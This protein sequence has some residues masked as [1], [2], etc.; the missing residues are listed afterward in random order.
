MPLKSP[1]QL[2]ANALVHDPEVAAVAGQRV[3]PVIAPF[4]AALPFVTWRRSSV[5]RVQTLSGPSGMAA[6]VLAVDMFADTY[7]AARELADR[8]RRVLDG[9]G[10]T[11]E[12]YVSVRSV[13]L[14]TESDGFVQLAGGD[15]PPVYQVSQTYS[16]LWQEI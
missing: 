12:N 16:V 3:Y 6:V 5:G 13:T 11:V 10:T 9:Y 4:S 15:L 1:E 14:D 7:E 2:I 8:V